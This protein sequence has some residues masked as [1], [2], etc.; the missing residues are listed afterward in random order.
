M[1]YRTLGSFF[2]GRRSS[3]VVRYKANTKVT[4]GEKTY[5]TSASIEGAGPSPTISITV[6]SS[7]A[8]S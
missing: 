2:H 4:V 6:S 1:E 5:F 8:P 7:F 3:G